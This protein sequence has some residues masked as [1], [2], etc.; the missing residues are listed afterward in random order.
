MIVSVLLRNELLKMFK[1]LAFWVTYTFFVGFTLIE[2]VD[3]FLE[4]RSN[5][6]D[7][8]ALPS[9]WP[10][11]MSDPEPAFFFGTIILMM[12]LASEFSWRTARQNV[13]DGLS[14][15]EWFLG[16][17]MLVP[18]LALLFL[19][20]H[21]F[22]GATFALLGSGDTS[23]PLIRAADWSAMAG[24]GLA[25]FGVASLGFF[26]A[27]AVRSSGAAIG[28]F[29]L[30]LVLIEQG[31]GSV[32]AKIGERFETIVHYLPFSTFQQL[33]NYRLHSDEA[34]RAAV[35]RAVEAGRTPPD[36]GDLS[37]VFMVTAIWIVVFTAGSFVWFRRRD[38]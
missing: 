18:I 24:V 4:A 20:A 26:I 21:L 5:P 1:R 22:L 33:T 3:E 25:F 9:A 37:M 8:F 29:F 35:Q 30:Y 15:E 2:F 23:E 16:K 27:Q 10:Q 7:P 14:K 6:N 28:V 19:G 36:Q 11:I 12:L 31:L 17:A 38:L 32:I 13:I 34:F